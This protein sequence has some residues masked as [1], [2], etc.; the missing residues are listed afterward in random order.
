[1]AAEKFTPKSD[2]PYPCALLALQEA[3]VALQFLD[4]QSLDPAAQENIRVL[5]KNLR[6]FCDTI[7][8][9]A[10]GSIIPEVVGQEPIE[11][12]PPDPAVA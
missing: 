7:I 12:T 10:L 4:I 3:R 6:S 11:S 5:T 2:Y 8:G 9:K 1:M